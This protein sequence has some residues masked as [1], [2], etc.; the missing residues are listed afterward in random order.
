MDTGVTAQDA[1]Q[2][3]QSHDDIMR[4]FRL[5]QYDDTTMDDLYEKTAS[6]FLELASEQRLH[7]LLKLQ[8]GTTNVSVIAKELDAT[9]PEVY[10]NFERLSK[11]D[12]IS[13]N[14]DG[15]YGITTIGKMFCSQVSLINFISRNKKYFKAHDF[16]QLPFKYIQRLGA[17][18]S[19]QHV[20]G[21]VKVQERWK[22]VYK[23]AEKYIYNI[24]FEVPYTPDITELLV[25]RISSGV[26]LRS[27]WSESAIIPKDR[28]QALEKFKEQIQQ[29]K[30]ERKM[31]DDV[32]T[33]VI[34]N[35]KEAGVMFPASGEVDMS[36]AFFSDDKMFHEW[37]LDYFKDCWDSAGPFR[38]TKLKE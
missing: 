10:R 16:D 15:S 2:T 8:D 6:D 4:S 20:K 35:E 38:E 13:K 14:P 33:I 30:I 26:M 12:L 28:K 17:L 18:Q 19:G 3:G 11:A 23:N 22:D 32:K 34:L 5:L 25:K 37:C 21:F 36:E 7:I 24:L 29:G 31:Q 9:V 27:I 1:R